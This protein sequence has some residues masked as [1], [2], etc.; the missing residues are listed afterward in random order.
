MHVP[1]IP[2]TRAEI[3]EIMMVP[4]NIVS[5][6]V[7]PPS[8]AGVIFLSLLCCFVVEGLL[9]LDGL[10]KSV[11]RNQKPL[12]RQ[13]ICHQDNASTDTQSSHADCEPAS[14]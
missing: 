2:E 7:N 6:Q 8:E 14:T 5:P 10:H 3:Q 1:Q 12:L 4:R 13:T 9:T 11:C